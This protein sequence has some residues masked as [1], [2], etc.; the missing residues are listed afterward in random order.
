MEVSL[1]AAHPVMLERMR[2]QLPQREFV[3]HAFLLP[4]AGQVE[5]LKL[6]PSAAWAI[7]AHNPELLERVL[8]RL[9]V[10]PRVVAVAEAFDRNRAFTLLREGV[11]GL[12]SYDVLGRDLARAL[13]AVAAGAYWAPRLLLAGF[14][15]ELLTQLPGARL[16]P[17][18]A[19]LS[20]RERQVL[21][22]ILS[23]RSNKEIA[24]GLGISER[25]VKF[26]VSHLLHRYRVP[27]RHEL[28][29]RVL[30]ASVPERGRE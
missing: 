26:H 2:L 29:L 21:D 30:Q 6:L 8:V 15:D 4:D 24:A 3:V 14:I 27:S 28:M 18:M 20:A 23:R 12:V 17:A 10:Q 5:R 9:P 22:G 1:V 25:T 11:R 19:G 16:A 13:R 7:D